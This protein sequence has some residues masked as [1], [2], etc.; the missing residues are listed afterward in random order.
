[1]VTALA[2]GDMDAVA[3]H[4]KGQNADKINDKVNMVRLCSF[5]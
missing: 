5:I 1:M 4:F 2:L 3:K